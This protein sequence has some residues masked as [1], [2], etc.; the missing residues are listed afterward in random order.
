MKVQLNC[1]GTSIYNSICILFSTQVTYSI[2]SFGV[3]H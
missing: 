2:K 1:D 3:I